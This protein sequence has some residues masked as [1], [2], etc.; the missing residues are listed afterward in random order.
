MLSFNASLIQRKVYY[1]V[2]NTMAPR[3]TFQ[4]VSLTI[5][6][7]SNMSV[8]AEIVWARRLQ[9]ERQAFSRQHILCSLV[10][11]D[12]FVFFPCSHCK[13]YPVPLFPDNPWETLA[14][15]KFWTKHD[16]P[17]RSRVRSFTLYTNIFLK[18]IKYASSKSPKI[19]RW[20]RR[21][22]SVLWP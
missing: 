4:S 21:F 19:P 6:N 18:G 17:Q 11:R 9:L 3:W 8:L 22:C 12:F 10:S 2:K 20:R 13:N 7:I 5:T 1:R 15:R 16:V 14:C